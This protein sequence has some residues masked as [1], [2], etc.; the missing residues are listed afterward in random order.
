MLSDHL[1]IY[2]CMLSKKVVAEVHA[3]HVCLVE[4][5]GD[6]PW[7]VPIKAMLFTAGLLEGGVVL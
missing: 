2:P 7:D 5:I 6:R 4:I 3:S 1:V